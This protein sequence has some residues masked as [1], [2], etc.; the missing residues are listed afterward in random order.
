MAGMKSDIEG[1]ERGP[2][3]NS[4]EFR[5][6]KAQVIT[7]IHSGQLSLELIPVFIKIVCNV[8]RP[9]RAMQDQVLCVGVYY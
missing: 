4:A 9:D 6:K 1:E 5:I 3:R 2:N 7:Q 8:P